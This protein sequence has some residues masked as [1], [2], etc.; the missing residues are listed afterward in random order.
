VLLLLVDGT[1]LPAWNAFRG[2]SPGRSIARSRIP[3]MAAGNARAPV[4]ALRVCL[5]CT[6]DVSVHLPR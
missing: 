2:R 5:W 1:G 3:S 6:G 4:G